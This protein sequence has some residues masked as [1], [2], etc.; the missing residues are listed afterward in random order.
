MP[1]RTPILYTHGYGKN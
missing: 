1:R